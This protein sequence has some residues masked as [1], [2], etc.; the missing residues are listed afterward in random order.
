MRRSIATRC[1]ARSLPL[2][3][4]LSVAAVGT[5]GC[6]ATGNDSDAGADAA[7]DT[8]PESDGIAE[9]GGETAGGSGPLISHA[10]WSPVDGSDDPIADHRPSSVDCPEDAVEQE[11][12]QGENT[13]AIDTGTCNYYAARQQTLADI[14]SGDELSVRIWHFELTADQS[15]EAHLALALDGNVVWE[16]SVPLP[17]SDGALITE[18]WEASE[19][20]PAGT[21]VDFHL[22]NHGN[23]TWNLIEFSRSA[24]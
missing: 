13:L 17:K 16:T 1:S 10:S 9:D 12:L 6:W 23:N 19:D 7:T 4:L 22:H 24:P 14:D 20:Y 18:T 3:A 15:A 2:I 11:Q 5:A 21:R 8:A